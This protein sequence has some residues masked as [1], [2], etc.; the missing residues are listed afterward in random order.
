MSVVKT[1]FCPS[2]TGFIHIGNARVALFN[3]LYAIKNKGIF[4]LRIE[5]TDKERSKQQF[6]DQLCTD[7]TWLGLEWQE[8][9]G[10]G[11]DFEP[12]SQS[13]RN[14]IYQKYL[15]KLSQK[16]L[17][18]PCFCSAETLETSRKIQLK[19][20]QPPRYDKSCQNLKEVDLAK[21][22]T[23]RFKV[24]EG[25][26]VFE[27]LVKGRQVF[28]NEHIGDLII[29]R[30]TGNIGF[31]FVNAVDDALMEVSHAIRGEDHLTN[32]PRQLMMLNALDLTPPTYAHIALTLGSDGKPLSKRNGSIS[33]TELREKGYFAIALQNHF[34]RL[35]HTYSSNDLMSLQELGEQFDEKRI[36]KAPAKFDIKHLNHW[37]SLSI[38][39]QS[40]EDLWAW[41][42]K[43]VADIVPKD[44]QLEF[45]NA[46]RENI[47]FPEDAKIIA[48]GLWTQ[49]EIVG[50]E[51]AK[52]K[53]TPAQ[54]F[55]ILLEAIAQDLVYSD[56][57]EL[58][59]EK[60]QLKGKA[61]FQPIRIA[62]T[63]FGHGPEMKRIYP[64]LD[65]ELLIKRINTLL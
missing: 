16:G 39:K 11:G 27:D 13:Q 61:L 49:D 29:Q 2:P 36:A 51:L 32:T 48:L 37:Q 14:D 9:Y 8:G 30:S 52:I 38:V 50:D 59:K 64:L 19:M 3:F 58:V 1:R 10:K 35:G 42:A 63:T 41:M 54:L 40:D 23:I 47:L 65:K 60:T 12:Y 22:H 33:I 43:E 44:K 45:V 26:V 15:A 25:K 55:E 20:G 7:L 28:N 18:Y 5:D 31:F 21:Q 57:L 53:E 56:L 17:T 24:D 34:A 4:L 62:L 46:V 6:I